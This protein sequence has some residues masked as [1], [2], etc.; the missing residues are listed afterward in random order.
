MSAVSTAYEHPLTWLCALQ[1]WKNSVPPEERLNGSIIAA[2]LL[3]MGI[4]WL[5]WTGAYASVHWIV[6]IL[7]LIPVSA[8]R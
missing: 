6:P 4:F 3:V 1:V 2:P 8:F 7:A 5:G